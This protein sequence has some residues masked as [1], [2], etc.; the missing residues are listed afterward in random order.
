M[1]KFTLKVWKNGNTIDRTLDIPKFVADIDGFTVDSQ[2]YYDAVTLT[3]LDHAKVQAYDNFVKKLAE[4]GVLYDEW[5]APDFE[6]P[7]ELLPTETAFLNAKDALE[8][9]QK[10]I[11]ARYSE[12][13]GVIPKVTDKIVK[14]YTWS[15]CGLKVNLPLTGLADLRKKAIDY[16][17]KY[18]G[19]QE[20][21]GTRKKAFGDLRQGINTVLNTVFDTRNDST[22]RYK[23]SA[24]DVSAKLTDDVV[25][26]CA[27]IL[28]AD[29]MGGIK[30]DRLKE[31]ECTKQVIFA[32]LRTQGC[33]S[34]KVKKN[35][36]VLTGW[37]V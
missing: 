3:L 15:M 14:A 24:A 32:Y 5:E 9:F 35:A 28:K 26:Y 21:D 19:I 7:E 33:D 20:W 31:Q 25:G 10:S 17:E 13:K 37:D 23:K 36:V 12:N 34:V 29:K 30:K 16:S 1:K 2:R 4:I 27:G 18:Y 6:T 8:S 22:G 11:E